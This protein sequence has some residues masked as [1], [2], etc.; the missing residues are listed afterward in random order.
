MTLPSGPQVTKSRPREGQVMV[1][2]RAGSGVL[3]ILAIAVLLAGCSAGAMPTPTPTLAP[4]LTATPT[5]ARV[6]GTGTCDITS[7]SDDNSG[8]T[9]VIREHFRCTNHTNDPRV[10]G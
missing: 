6:R 3:S 10:N 4:T 8:T 1:W 2:T 9:W 5:V 7:R